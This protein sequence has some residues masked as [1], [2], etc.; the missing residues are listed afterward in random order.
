MVL[1]SRALLP[2]NNLTPQSHAVTLPACQHRHPTT[3][4]SHRHSLAT[5]PLVAPPSP[6]LP[7]PPTHPFTLLPGEGE[8]DLL[9]ALAGMGGAIQVELTEADAAAIERL[10]VRDQRAPGE[11][12]E[13]GGG[14]GQRG[15][16]LCVGVG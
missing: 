5:W 7:P 16:W 11:G 14:R 6:L 1:P 10:Q 12:R 9:G 13:G 15:C 4:A 2:C 3:P 8:E